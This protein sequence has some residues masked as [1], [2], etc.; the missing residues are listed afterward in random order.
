MNDS[1]LITSY[2]NVIISWYKGKFIVVMQR[3]MVF[4]LYKYPLLTFVC[5]SIMTYYQ[6]CSRI[7]NAR[8]KDK[9]FE[10]LFVMKDSSNNE[11]AGQLFV[12]TAV[13][14]RNR[15]FRLPLSSKA[16]KRSVLLPTKR[17]KCKDLVWYFSY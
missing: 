11:S 5:H 6:I 3:S 12:D 2:E 4:L 14:S 15:C 9:S 13:Y 7:L 10:K 17:F 16:G 1:M 8:E